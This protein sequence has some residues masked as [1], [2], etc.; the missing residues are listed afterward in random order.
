M[1]WVAAAGLIMTLGACTTTKEQ[2]PDPQVTP[3]AWAELYDFDDFSRECA[4][5]AGDV[6]RTTYQVQ[7]TETRVLR[8]GKRFQGFYRA[9]R[10][11]EFYTTTG[12]SAET[13]RFRC[14]MT[15]PGTYLISAI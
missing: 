2:P 13:Y 3:R 14:E 4:L 11:V 10:I 9:T 5:R 6:L 7:P 12:Q 1:R 15:G 8:L